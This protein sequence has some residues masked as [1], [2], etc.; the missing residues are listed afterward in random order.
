MS[1]RPVVLKVTKHTSLLA[2]QLLNP[3]NE[4]VVYLEIGDRTAGDTA[5][6][7]DDDLQAALVEGRW[8]FTHRDGRPY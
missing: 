1:L 6:Y 7:R 5:S 8:V 3:T 4:P 2:H